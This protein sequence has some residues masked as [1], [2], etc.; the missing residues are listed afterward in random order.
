[1]FTVPPS[2]ELGTAWHLLLTTVHGKT[3]CL[4]DPAPAVPERTGP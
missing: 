3:A 4:V 1:M 2:K